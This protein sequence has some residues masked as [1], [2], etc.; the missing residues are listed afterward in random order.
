M[1]AHMTKLE[2]YLAVLILLLV[3]G[4]AQTPHSVAVNPAQEYLQRSDKITLSAGN[5]KEVNSNIQVIDPWPRYVGNTRIPG[6]GERMAGAVERYRDVSKQSRGPQLL[7]TVGTTSSP[8][9]SS[10]GGSGAS[11]SQ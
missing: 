2:K 3:G 6:N 1:A 4:C 11:L 5:A 7:P 8:G 9:A 10:T